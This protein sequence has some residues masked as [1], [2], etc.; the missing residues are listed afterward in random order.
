[1]KTFNWFPGHM[2]KT[3]DQIQQN[4]SLVDIVLLMLDA[5]TP[6]SSINFK[7]LSLIKTYQKP[8]LFLLNKFSLTDSQKIQPFL[9]YYFQNK[10]SVLKIDA[11]KKNKNFAIYKQALKI[12]QTPNPCF[13]LKKSVF[14]NKPNIKM[15]IVGMPNVGKSTLINGFVGKKVLKT[16]NAAGTTK[17][18]QWI[19]TLHPNIQFLDTPGVLYHR[20]YDKTISLSL[21]LS[22]SFKDSVLPLETLG[23]CAL[24]YLK[25][26]YLNNLIKRFDLSM[27]DQND[28]QNDNLIDLIGKK[29]NFYICNQKIDEKKVYQVILQEI[30]EGRLGKINFDLDILP[31][32][33]HFFK[34]QNQLT[35]MI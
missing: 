20:F 3:F 17:K 8:F 18:T 26:H 12:I 33:D 35:K 34:N 29:R 25:K 13:K 27:L 5:R 24:N 32:L 22:G 9:D 1:M 21:A 16:A 2:K 30:R 28:I 11:I 23:E 7:L 14:A 10:I 19:K 15:M 31:L 6:F 4:L